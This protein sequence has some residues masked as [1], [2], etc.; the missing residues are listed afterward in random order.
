MKSKIK[1]EFI[2]MPFQAFIEKCPDAIYLFPPEYRDMFLSDPEYI[3]RLSDD[4]S[5]EIGYKS[6]NWTIDY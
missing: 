3:V 5:L 4:G 6:D 1:R 2:E